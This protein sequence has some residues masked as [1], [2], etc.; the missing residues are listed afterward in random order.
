QTYIDEINKLIETYLSSEPNSGEQIALEDIRHTIN[1]Y[2]SSMNIIKQ[3]YSENISAELID[4]EVIID[5]D[6]ALRGFE[7]LEAEQIDQIEAR[8]GAVANVINQMEL[9]KSIYSI[10]HFVF[11]VLLIISLNYII[12]AFVIKP[13]QN[14]SN[15][16]NR[17][18]EGDLDVEISKKTF[19]DNE[20]GKLEKAFKVFKEHEIERT[21]SEAQLRKLAM[22]DVLTGLANRAQ[23][24][25][26]YPEL[27]AI[28]KRKNESIATLMLDLDNFKAVNDSLG[29]GVGDKLLQTVSETL[30][31]ELR[32][33]DII[34]RLGGDE[35][36]I[37]LYAPNTQ[38]DVSNTA[39]R[40][41]DNISKLEPAYGSNIRVGT[42]I[43]I[44]IESD[45]ITEDINDVLEKA[46]KAL[47]DA[48]NTGKNK[49]VY[50]KN[51]LE[52]ENP[53]RRIG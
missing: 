11:F 49:Y 31:S 51:L 8:A 3:R 16:L 53:I 13:I 22:T 50:H 38:D 4:K 46:D 43:G 10:F 2:E 24:E 29:H 52:L 33:T 25:R 39:Q 14:V 34:A 5:D 30:M 23:L 15:A 45:K 41:I 9:E 20:I 40:I 27:T 21:K 47:Y 44:V 7:L 18:A 12:H 35:F 26:R 48:K 32:D 19:N 1:E 6:I 17:L 37:I 28:A 36:V 42:S